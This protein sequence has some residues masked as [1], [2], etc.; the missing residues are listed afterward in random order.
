MTDPDLLDNNK[1]GPAQII[2]VTQSLAFKFKFSYSSS[3]S[4]WEM[5]RKKM[6]KRK[7]K[8]NIKRQKKNEVKGR[9]ITNEK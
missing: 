4:L 2:E 8:M 3:E 9:K 7:N 6:I 1:E 5:R